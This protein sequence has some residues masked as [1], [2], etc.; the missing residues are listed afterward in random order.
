M[1]PDGYSDLAPGKI[2]SIVTYLEMLQR[3]ALQDVSAA[4]VRLRQVQNPALDWYRTLF[5]RAGAQWLWFSR[6]EMKDDQ[7]AAVLNS[8]NVE[9]FLAESEGR[10][11]GI[12]ELD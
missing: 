11:I 4:A 9:F 1:I 6:L 3:P 12:A 5:R 10:E 2:A 7:L 8:A